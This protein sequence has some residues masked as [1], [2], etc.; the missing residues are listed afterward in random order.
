[1]FERSLEHAGRLPARLVDSCRSRNAASYPL[2]PSLDL[3]QDYALITQEEF[4]ETFR[5]GHSMRDAF[6][7]RYPE[8]GG[9]VTF[10]RVGFGPKGDTA[11]VRMAFVCGDLC[12]AGGLYLL[13]KE[14][15]S[16]RVQEHLAAWMS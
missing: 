2:S 7:A 11:L 12:G 16:W 3:E 8:P 1:M 13:A 14:E 9:V 6:L 15:G 5:G 10:S 4:E